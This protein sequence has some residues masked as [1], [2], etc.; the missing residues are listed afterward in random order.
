MRGG[1]APSALP[2][3]GG[4]GPHTPKSGRSARALQS[5]ARRPGSLCGAGSPC[6]PR[7]RRSALHPGD[8]PVAGK[9]TK[10]A[11]RAV[12]FGIPRRVVAALFALA[13][14]SR[15]A[16]FCHKNR[17]I[18]HF[19]LVGKSVLFFLWFHQGNTLCFQSVARQVGCPRGCLKVSVPATNTARAGGRGIKGGEAPFAGGPGTRR[20]LA[21]LCLLSLREKVGRGAGRSA[22]IRVERRGGRQPSSH[23]GAQRGEVPLR[24]KK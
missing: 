5:Y 1:F 15:R 23:W 19:E 8:F 24:I 4:W 2:R 9:V 12:P 14:A 17:P 13:Y 6:G 18:C 22:R 10:G 16:T 7:C 11:P 3:S 20:S 21:Y